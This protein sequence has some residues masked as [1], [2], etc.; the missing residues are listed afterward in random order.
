LAVV[1]PS[2]LVRLHG[3]PEGPTP[4][5]AHHRLLAEL[6]PAAIDALVEVAASDSG[7][8]LVSVEVRHLGGGLSHLAAPLVLLAVGNAGSSE[9]DGASWSALTDTVPAIRP[10]AAPGAYLDFVER[11]GQVAFD[12]VDGERLLAVR[13][14]LD[15]DGR[16][17]V[18]A[19]LP[20]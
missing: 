3:D 16:F 7:N 14:R 13:N 15:P 6:G 8:P 1:E 19:G 5:L 9:L 17:A 4:G 20:G 11:P 18:R 12:G 2:A 10:W